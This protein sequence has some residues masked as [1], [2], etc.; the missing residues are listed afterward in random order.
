MGERE[1]IWLGFR[2]QN[3]KEI[4]APSTNNVPSQMFKQKQCRQLVNTW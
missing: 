1:N 3:N 4:T 2:F